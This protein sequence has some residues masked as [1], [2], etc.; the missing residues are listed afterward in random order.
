MLLL[1]FLISIA[2]EKNRSVSYCNIFMIFMVVYKGLLLI[3]CFRV[4]Y[5]KFILI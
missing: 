5:P 4:F 2:H 1:L 3:S